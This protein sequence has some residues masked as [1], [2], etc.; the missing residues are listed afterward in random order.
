VVYNAT[1]MLRIC[2]HSGCHTL[3]MGVRCVMHE[4]VVDTGPFPRGR[5]FGNGRLVTDPPVGNGVAES[6]HGGLSAHAAQSVKR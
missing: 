4:P 5:P 3:T 6:E 2:N 1:Q